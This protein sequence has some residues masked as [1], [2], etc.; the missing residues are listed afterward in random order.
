MVAA[1]V[2]AMD[3]SDRRPVGAA[4]LRW[5]AIVFALAIWMALRVA[6]GVKSFDLPTPEAVLAMVRIYPEAIAI[7]FWRALALVP[8]TISHPYMAGGALGDAAGIAIFAALV[9]ATIRWRRLA[10]PAAIFLAGFVP[11]VGAMAMFH[12]ASERYFYIPSIGLALLVADLVALALSAQH[13]PECMTQQQAKLAA[14]LVRVVV[15]AAVGIVV[16]LGIVRIERRLPDWRSNDTLWAA[17]LKVNP[18]DPQANFN[19]AI[20]AGHRG[21]WGEALRAIEVAAHGDPSS[22]RIAGTYAWAL[23]RTAD[24]AGAVREAEHATALAPYQPD[25]WYYLAFA[26]HKIGDHAGELAAIEKLLQIAPDFPGAME[27]HE[28]AACEVS[29]R[30]DCPNGH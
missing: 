23:L 10:V 22:G 18:L 12:E 9:A 13:R 11:I 19:H 27:M 5:V 24:F 15:P 29:G 16:L 4:A 28:I 8:L 2:A 21:D 6:V 3:F 26:R 14:R 30:T 1:V 7:Y 20:A 25:C 17:A